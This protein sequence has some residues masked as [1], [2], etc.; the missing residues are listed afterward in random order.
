[1]LVPALD[2]MRT[3]LE[4]DPISVQ[5]YLAFLKEFHIPE[6][7]ATMK[8]LYALSQGA[9]GDPQ[10][11]IAEII[12]RNNKML[13]KA[14]EEAD[15]NQLAAMYIDFLLPQLTAGAVVLADMVLYILLYLPQMSKW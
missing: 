1:M 3:Q 6:I 13:D 11:Q 7:Q 5:P 2:D 10:E 9:G 15:E 8:M 12:T 4:E 14:E